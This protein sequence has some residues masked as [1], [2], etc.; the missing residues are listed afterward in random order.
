MTEYIGNYFKNYCIQR[1]PCFMMQGSMD[2][3]CL[4][5]HLFSPKLK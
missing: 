2:T 3:N 5:L 4:G 1:F